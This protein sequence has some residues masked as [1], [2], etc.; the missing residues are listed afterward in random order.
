MPVVKYDDIKRQAVKMEGVS[1]T[2]KANVIG[3][4]EGWKDNA[5]RVFRV[6]P[7]GYTPH[8][9]HDWEHVNHVIR[10]KGTLTIG[11]E[12]FELNEKDFALVPPNT[13]H[14]Y[15]NPYDEDFEFICIVPE[16][17]AH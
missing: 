2:T 4:N 7:G 6:G 10:G 8:H 15:R 5:M 13:K 11:G 1:N 9:R 17:G 16:H 3:L 12:T 14:Q